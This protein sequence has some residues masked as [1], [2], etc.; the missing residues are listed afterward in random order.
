MKSR[1]KTA[2]K[3]GVLVL[4]GILCVGSLMGC[5]NNSGEE[6]YL[7]ENI[8]DV[9]LFAA[10]DAGYV[11]DPMPFYEDGEFHIF[12][13]LDKRD[14]SNGYH[15]WALY[16]TENFYEY[17]DCGEVIPYAD[18]LNA[19]DIALGTGSVIKD[20]DGMY[21]AF[22][23]GHNDT[24][25]PKEAIMHAT[26]KDMKDW[27]KLP[28]DTFSANAH[29]SQNDFRDPYVLY[30]EEEKEYW[31]LITTRN[32]KTGIIAKYTSKDLKQWKDEGT[33][34]VN[35]MDTDSNMECP[36]LLQYQGK[37]YLTFSDQWPMREFHYRVSDTPDGKFEIPKQDIIDGNGFYAGR[38]ETD[39][40]NLY[41]FGWNATKVDHLDEEEYDWGGN[42]VVHQLVQKEDGSLVPIMN[43]SV[44]EGMKKE[45]SLTP[46]R[47]T[48]TIEKHKR[49]Y[50]L[51]GKEYEVVEFNT[52]LGSYRFETTIKN[53]KD[54]EKFGFAFQTD[55]EAVGAMNIVFDVKENKIEFFNTNEL[56][57]MDPQSEI[58]I[59]F[60]NLEELKV[61]MM[62][63]DGVV[64]MYV[65][66]QCAMTAR[67]YA[68]QGGTWGMFGINS[69][70]CF[71]DVRI[72]K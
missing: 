41:A 62:I 68:S 66:E 59:D 33:F 21:H 16:N 20:E 12:Y 40:E 46:L 71:E 34:F 64:S 26:S 17:E 13:L 22:Y 58:D 48:E 11:G 14:G 42:L 27:T 1:K 18:S 30:M 69:N 44:K 47:M 32:E 57:A 55:D 51:S 37:W 43:A 54:S 24:Y 8:E 56:Y 6:E 5:S 67:M 65:D 28:E 60:E 45:L 10:S 7:G 23:T 63:A 72:Y 15:P 53:F 2:Q 70:V 31:M 35:D 39:G 61:S 52:L 3:T 36:T 25:S 4:A 49:D 9:Q 29:Y 38:L 19:Q 50:E